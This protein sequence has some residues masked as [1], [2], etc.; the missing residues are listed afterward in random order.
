[1][2][3][4]PIRSSCKICPLPTMTISRVCTVGNYWQWFNFIMGPIGQNQ[5]FARLRQKVSLCIHAV[6]LLIG[7]PS[8]EGKN[9]LY[10]GEKEGKAVSQTQVR[11]TIISNQ[12]HKGLTVHQDILHLSKLSMEKVL[13]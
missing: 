1:M 12:Q 3:I 5:H 4:L 10:G 9:E 6:V 11:Q 13:S 7:L 2:L 8:L